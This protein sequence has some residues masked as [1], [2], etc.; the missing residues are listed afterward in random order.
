[1]LENIYNLKVISDSGYSTKKEETRNR[2][3]MQGLY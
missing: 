3:G 2:F 1:M